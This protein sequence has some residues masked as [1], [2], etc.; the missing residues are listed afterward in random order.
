MA[1]FLAS[2]SL[3]KNIKIDSRVGCNINKLDKDGALLLEDGGIIYHG[4]Q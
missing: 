1:A 2:P 4:L 3:M